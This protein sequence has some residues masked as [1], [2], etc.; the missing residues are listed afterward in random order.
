MTGPVSVPA[1]LAGCAGLAVM[2]GMVS[3][4]AAPPNPPAGQLW[5]N[6][7]STQGAHLELVE[8]QRRP[9]QAGEQVPFPYK[10]GSTIVVYRLRAT[11]LAPGK[12][13]DLWLHL[14]FQKPVNTHQV[15]EVDARG[16]VSGQG[17]PVSLPV[18][19]YRKGEAIGAGLISPDGAVRA[20]ASTFPF[21][22]QATDGPCR[23]TLELLDRAGTTFGAVMRG[24]RPGSVVETVSRSGQEVLRARHTV[25]PGGTFNVVLR[26]AAPS[27]DQHASFAAQAPDC[28]VKVDYA[29]GAASMAAQ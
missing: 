27:G 18:V 23:L 3:A 29:W 10:V 12:P 22:L 24:F 15:V 26:P 14:S 5:G 19:N 1:R 28:Q 9:L 20:I 2:L 17:G 8:V 7:Q 16:D 25:P 4:A 13:Y 21:P 11:G 6:G